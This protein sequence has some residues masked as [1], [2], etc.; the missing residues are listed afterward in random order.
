[1]DDEEFGEPCVS[2]A[3]DRRNLL[4][5]D[6]R[7][8]QAP[9]P[10]RSPFARQ[11]NLFIGV[12]GTLTIVATSLAVCLSSVDPSQSRRPWPI[13]GSVNFYAPT[14]REKAAK[15]RQRMGNLGGA[16]AAVAIP[17][18]MQ[19][20]TEVFPLVKGR[21]GRLSRNHRTV[22]MGGFSRPEL[23][24]RYTERFGLDYVVAQRETY[25]TLDLGYF[26][27][28][29]RFS[30]QWIIGW[31]E[32]NLEKIRDKKI[33]DY[34]AKGPVGDDI[35]DVNRPRGWSE[36]KD[37]KLVEAPMAGVDI[38][39]TQEWLMNNGQHERFDSLDAYPN[40]KRPPYHPIDYFRVY[41]NGLTRREEITSN[42]DYNQGT[43]NDCWA[44][45]IAELVSRLLCI[46]SDE[47]WTGPRAFL[48]PGYI[49]SCA[50]PA[51][52]D[53][54]DGCKSGGM[55]LQALWWI[56]EHGVPT[57]G[58]AFS[59]QTCVPFFHVNRSSPTRAPSCPSDCT[60]LNY[61]RALKEDLFKPEGLKYTYQTSAL[62]SALKAMKEGPIAIIIPL[63][64]DFYNYTG[65]VYRHR[66]GKRLGQH[67]MVAHGYQEGY[68]Q[69][70][71]SWGTTW[72]Y[73]G[74]YRVPVSF[75]LAFIIPGR[76]K[77]HG[78]GYP[79]PFPDSTLHVKMSG[80]DD[81]QLNGIFDLW[82]HELGIINGHP[83]YWRGD[84]VLLY[85]FPDDL[86]WAVVDL[87][88]H[89]EM[90]LNFTVGDQG[91]RGEA[92]QSILRLRQ[93]LQ[94]KGVWQARGPVMTQYNSLPDLPG[95][96]AQGWFEILPTGGELWRPLAGIVGK[97][98]K[99]VFTT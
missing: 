10:Q 48:S 57:G 27:Y 26:L 15:D 24:A 12:A 19:N 97:S 2:E 23:N 78:D 89:T 70:F 76:I 37:G 17:F 91:W 11:R 95:T 8:R 41:T 93:L 6:G 80:F 29:C 56:A 52:V 79:Y 63:Y 51:F 16:D 46:T 85:Y 50:Q 31:G 38:L 99:L 86:H 66:H 55:P 13:T 34:T 28:Y 20:Y 75:P 3:E 82:V 62:E 59:E 90:R 69:G 84:S 4:V 58:E 72:G 45:T 71:N 88:K 40:C 14:A 9:T 54:S 39:S 68:I 35:L 94:K 47:R 49:T 30:K 7:L 98:S 21:P 25:W 32:H 81:K 96:Y 77:G 83:T 5:V 64:E 1:M 74:N 61:P 36:W 18:E 60:G 92:L 87:K 44:I 67:V 42:T 33:C 22:T 73:V 65:G 43:C 53:K